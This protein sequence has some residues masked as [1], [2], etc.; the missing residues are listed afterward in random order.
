MADQTRGDASTTRHGVADDLM[1]LLF[2]PA[3]GTIAGENTLFYVL[4][5]AVL[6][7]LALEGAVR[8]DDLGV[9]GTVV[10]A[11]GDTAPDDEILRTMWTY[12]SEKPRGVQTVLAAI[13]PQLRS[14]VLDRLVERG[15]LRRTRGKALGF[16]PTETL[17]LGDTGRREQLVAAVRATLVDGAEPTARTATLAALLSASGALP[18]LHPEIPWS[19]PVATRA[20]EL[21]RGDFAA[22][23]A[24]AAVTRTMTAVIVNAM[25][26]AGVTSAR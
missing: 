19:T 11:E 13:G 17:E 24:A 3:S 6:T 18:T 23:A 4:A 21:E 14:P 5:G 22:D 10:T 2:S 9:R 25:I 7:D 8:A 20:K 26:V 1:L 12:I 15:D 16:I